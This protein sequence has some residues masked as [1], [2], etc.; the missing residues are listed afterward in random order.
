M[1]IKLIKSLGT[2]TVLGV[3]GISAPLILTA[4]PGGNN[5]TDISSKISIRNLQD[6][7][8]IP[9]ANQIL[10]VINNRNANIN[11]TMNDVE[12]TNINNTSATIN[13]KGKYK[14]SVTVNF[15]IENSI[16]N[17]ITFTN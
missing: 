2:I 8:A 16:S 7:G 4:C 15:K 14:G 10:S 17:I 13:G 6:F 1:K 12:I 3:I 9:D 11:L 5:K